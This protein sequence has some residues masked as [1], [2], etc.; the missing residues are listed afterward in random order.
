MRAA[1]AGP[2]PGTS[3]V[4]AKARDAVARIFGKA[5]HREHVLDVRGFEELQ[6]AEFHERDV[7]AGQL[8][9]ERVGSD[10]TC[11]TAPPAT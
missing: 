4:H 10:A 8:E 5:Q 9:F 1:L 7:A 6:P 11:G 3:C 2:M